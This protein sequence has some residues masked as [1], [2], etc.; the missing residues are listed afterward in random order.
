[1]STSP[2]SGAREIQRLPSL[3]YYNELKRETRF[4]LELDAAK[5]AHYMYKNM[6]QIKVVDH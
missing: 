2:R 5:N 1:M 3:K 4:T 6:L